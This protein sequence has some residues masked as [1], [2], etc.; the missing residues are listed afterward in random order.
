MGY[1]TMVPDYTRETAHSSFS[2][3]NQLL[4]TKTAMASSVF[5]GLLACAS[6]CRADCTPT[7]IPG[8]CLPNL[9]VHNPLDDGRGVLTEPAIAVAGAQLSTWITASRNS[10]ISGAQPLTADMRDATAGFIPD[11]VLNRAR[12]EIGDNGV[13][14]TANVIM[15][16]E[17]NV[18]AVTLDDVIVFRSWDVAHDI[19]V[20]VHELTH[21]KQYTDW[22]VNN[23]ATSYVRNWHSVEDPA[24]ATRDQ[25]WR[26]WCQKFNYPSQCAD[27]GFVP[28]NDQ[29]PN[30]K[31]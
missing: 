19:T 3:I 29:G 30:I 4:T 15:Q 14:N 12:F 7:S 27:W 10:A 22:G 18:S 26:W 31:G 16:N 6:V 21:V 17:P 23:F 20:L 11:Y 2:I 13:L 28:E 9:P 1:A 25:Y 5:M 8:V 24:Y